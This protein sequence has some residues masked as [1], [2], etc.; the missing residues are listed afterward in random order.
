VFGS[1]LHA[2]L[3]A[4]VEPSKKPKHQAPNPEA[5]TPR[6]VHAQISIRI[7]RDALR[8]LKRQAL[9]EDTSLKELFFRAVNE[10]RERKGLKKLDL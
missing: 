7:K 10:L 2:K 3:S 5:D 8:E 4:M 9:D 6:G 1:L